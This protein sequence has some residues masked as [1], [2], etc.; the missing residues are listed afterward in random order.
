[1]DYWDDNDNYDWCDYTVNIVCGTVSADGGT[2][3]GNNTRMYCMGQDAITLTA[4]N[5]DDASPPTSWVIT[6]A[7]S[8]D[9]SFSGDPGSS[10]A[11]FTPGANYTGTVTINAIWGSCTGTITLVVASVAK[12]QYKDP[13]DGSYVDAPN[14]LYILK[15]TPV[16]FKAVPAPD[17]TAFPDNSPSWGGTAGASGSGDTT[18]FTFNDMSS[19]DSDYKTVTATCGNS[20]VSL[21]VIVYDIQG[22]LTPDDNFTSRSLTEFGVCE[23]IHLSAT[24]TPSFSPGYLPELRWYLPSGTGGTLANIGT[25]GT[26]DYTAPEL[27]C[28]GQLQLKVEDGISRNQVRN[29]SISIIA[30]SGIWVDK[31]ATTPDHWHTQGDWSVGFE[32]QPYILPANVSFEMILVK[33]DEQNCTSA[34]GYLAGF[35]GKPHNASVGSASVGPGDAS[36]GCKVLLAA[37]GDKIYASIHP[38]PMPYTSGYAVWPIPWDWSVTGDPGTWVNFATAI[39]WIYAP[40]DAGGTA[41]IAKQGSPQVSAQVNDASS[42]P[43]NW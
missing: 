39:Q 41:T 28:S 16:T 33:E 21:N 31:I 18:M 30:P 14:P 32:G 12:I 36:K 43:P 25:D 10:T 4:A 17:G 3:I 19:S 13:S 20:A 29:T 11:T 35:F 42:T 5:C 1:M 15:G 26:A 9:C 6:P 22:V 38:A 27:A 23:V 7:C 2:D 37:G 40:G 8:G 24:T 34:S